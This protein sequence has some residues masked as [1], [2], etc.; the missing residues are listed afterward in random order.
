MGQNPQSI[1]GSIISCTVS[2]W[3]LKKNKPLLCE[4]SLLP[5]GRLLYSCHPSRQEHRI[6]LWFFPLCVQKYIHQER[7][8][9][10]NHNQ[11]FPLKTCPWG[12]KWKL[13]H[14][15][16]PSI[17]CI[18]E[19]VPMVASWQGFGRCLVWLHPVLPCLGPGAA[20]DAAD[21]P[22]WAELSPGRTGIVHRCQ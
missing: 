14:F 6:V 1:A 22:G 5:H 12:I 10:F 9:A 4:L 2:F 17:P 21:S 13:K 11:R 7:R 20:A 15:L 18:S 19:A 3:C 8:A 16:F